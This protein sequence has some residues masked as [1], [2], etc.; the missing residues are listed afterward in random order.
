MFFAAPDESIWVGTLRLGL[1]IPASRSL[2]DRRRAVGQIR[3][4]L[5]SRPHLVV[6]DVGHLEDRGR[7]VLAICTVSNDQRAV[8]SALDGLV[9]EIEGWGRVRV[10]SRTIDI[11]RPFALEEA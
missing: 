8:Q 7:A 9:Y 5:R 4:R 2:K 11:A 1:R 3:D 10:E 6:A